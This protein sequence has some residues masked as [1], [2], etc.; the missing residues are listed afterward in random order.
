MNNQNLMQ[1]LKPAI[2]KDENLDRAFKL[3]CLLESETPESQEVGFVICMNNWDWEKVLNDLSREQMDAIKQYI[4]EMYV[5]HTKH[6]LESEKPIPSS[7]VRWKKEAF[8]KIKLIVERK[9][10]EK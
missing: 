8:R 10:N 2:I 5:S 7:F 3:W 1:V 9:Y 6:Y 4:L